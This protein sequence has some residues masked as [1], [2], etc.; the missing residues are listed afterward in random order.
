MLAEIEKNREIINKRKEKAKEEREK[1][2]EAYSGY[3][4]ARF[5]FIVLLLASAVLLVMTDTQ[6]SS[7]LQLIQSHLGLSPDNQLVEPLD[8]SGN[9]TTPVNSLTI[10]SRLR[11]LQAIQSE[12]VSTPFEMMEE[13]LNLIESVTTGLPKRDDASSLTGQLSKF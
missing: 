9:A 3:S 8:P 4:N 11:E 5:Y 1:E 13:T 12:D 10:L 7:R 2:E 6:R